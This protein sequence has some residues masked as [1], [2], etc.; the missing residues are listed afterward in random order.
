[1][2]K[3][4]VNIG[5]RANDGTG[6]PLRTAFERIN[7]MFDE[8]YK[9]F[10]DGTTLNASED[11]D[12]NV[13]FT[14]EVEV[15]GNLIVDTDTLFVDTT[16]DRVGIND[17]T[18]SYDL[19][20]NGSARVTAAFIDSSGSAGTQG[21]ILTST[22][23]ATSWTNIDPIALTTV[24]TAASEAAHLALTTQEGDVVVRSD[25]NKTYIRNAGTAGTMDDFTE[26]VNPSYTLPEA[27]ATT[28]GGIELFSNTDQSV[29]AN[30]VS[31]TA[32]R[33]YGLQLNS[34]GQGVINVPWTDTVYTLPEATSTTRGGIELFSDTDQTVE[35]NA[36]SSTANRTYG[37]QLNSAGQAVVNV[38]WTDTDTN[39]FRTVTAGGNTLGAS[40]TLAFT[41]GTNVT[42]TENNGAVTISATDT[43]TVY[44]LP[45][46]TATV[47]GGI[48]L[49]SNTDQSVTANAV[50]SVAGRTYGVQLNSDGQAVV[51][52]PWTDTNTDT[53]TF[54]TVTA[55]GNTLG[56]SETLAFT[57]GSNIT[58][59]ENGGAVTIAATDTN[60]QL[61]TEQVQDIVGAMFSNNDENG[62][63]AIYQDS[64]GTI[65]LAVT[66]T[67]YTLPEATATTRGGIELFSNT[68]QSVTANSV[69][70][71][72]G[73]T[74]GIQLNSAG[75]AVVN[76]P[77]TD[78]NTNQ[79]TTF[80]V[81]DGDGTEVTISHGKEWK[82]VEGTGIDINWTDTSNG[83]DG[84]PYDLTIT[85]TAPFTGDVFDAD[86]TFASLRAQ[87]TTKADVGLGNVE[88]TALSTWSG[89]SNIT[90]LGTIATGTWNGTR[91]GSAYLDTDIVYISTTQTITGSKT[92]SATSSTTVTGDWTFQPAA[93]KKM[94]T[95]R[96]YSR[97][98][99]TNWINLSSSLQSYFVGNVQVL[100]LSSSQVVVNED[101][102]DVDFRVESNNKTHALW[103]NGADGTVHVGYTSEPS[104]TSALNVNGNISANEI[105]ASG[106]IS[107][108]TGSTAP[109]RTSGT[110]GLQFWSG[111][112]AQYTALTKDD[113]TIYYVTDE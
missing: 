90:T 11:S 16:N 18:P 6:H 76:V 88:N 23:S 112:K 78:T 19:D 105:D 2:G 47:R 87:G 70:S 107:Y 101:S 58:I 113:D 83:T 10:G 12:G 43:D 67:S 40:E 25:E 41:A 50:S 65:D 60:T 63:S 44:T 15:A 110:D 39:T 22:G 96:I 51:N 99:E 4:L 93:G 86:G 26:L 54:R 1:M 104:G 81:E 64:D 31:T 7:N 30:S 27:T 102:A 109:T 74:Y 92:F 34:A 98:S 68:D 59:T 71:T 21:Q 61:S 100:D 95:S 32:G 55:G 108:A 42:I 35:A 72:A 37:I 94:K 48:E 62:I 53:N 33:T 20:V 75:Q 24:Q 5:A 85:N 91:I 97:T 38:P 80:Q 3:Q 8:V 66:D 106:G 73:R 17:S 79:L 111:T 49:F 84:D 56:A 57:A 52:V 103:T 45:E 36:V 77:W 29:T 14:A 13:E 89:S 82:F 9:T 46:A 28:R 69:S